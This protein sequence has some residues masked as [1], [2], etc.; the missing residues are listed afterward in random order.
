[1]F[2]IV[3]AS[4][5]HEA[6]EH[7]LDITK[8]GDFDKYVTVVK[9]QNTDRFT[10]VHPMIMTEMLI[11]YCN[12]LIN[13]DVFGK[14]N[15][16]KT[17]S[18][19]S[20]DDHEL[21]P[22]PIHTKMFNQVEKAKAMNLNLFDE[23]QFNQYLNDKLKIIMRSEKN[24]VDSCLQPSRDLDFDLFAALSQF[25][26]IMFGK[27]FMDRELPNFDDCKSANDSQQL[28]NDDFEIIPDE[29]RDTPQIITSNSSMYDR[30][31]IEELD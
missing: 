29:K 20:F 18:Q 15:F 6:K 3:F 27:S 26:L 4:L 24:I 16:K 25:S 17:F 22:Y 8:E 31:R 13:L 11:A 21:C 30:S 14:V 1:M 9:N 23:T 5:V 28:G 2:K 7:K 10:R 12:Q 19:D